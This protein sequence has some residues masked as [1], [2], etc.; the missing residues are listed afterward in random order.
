MHVA[1][2]LLIKKTQ[3]ISA[4]CLALDIGIANLTHLMESDHVAHELIGDC[5]DVVSIGD[6]AADHA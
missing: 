5:V 6:A 4:E 1:V 2:W 3:N